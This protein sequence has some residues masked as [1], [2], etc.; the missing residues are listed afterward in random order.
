MEHRR[1][2]VDLVVEKEA[3]TNPLNLQLNQLNLEILELKV[4]EEREEQLILTGHLTVVVEAE[5][6]VGS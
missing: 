2:Q 3:E 6:L 1:Y 5:E 4:S